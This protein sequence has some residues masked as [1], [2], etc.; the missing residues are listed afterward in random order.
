MRIG[1]GYDVHRLTEDRRLVLGGVLVEYSLGLLGHSDADV[2]CHAVMD[3]LLGAAALGDIGFHY[4]DTNE[5]FRD[6][7][8]L[9]LLKD[10]SEK[11]RKAGYTIGNIDA[12]VVAQ[13][14]R[15][16]PYI[17]H[18]RRNIAEACS[19]SIDA[20]SVKATTEEGLGFT[21]SGEGI[22]SHAVC[23]LL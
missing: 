13:R 1:F 2:L 14:P 4:P 15:I 10:T 21:G 9:A 20:V 8:S 18:M 6:A 7:D 23:L 3:A 17:L 5:N 19:I 11:I 12:T 22:S 16:A